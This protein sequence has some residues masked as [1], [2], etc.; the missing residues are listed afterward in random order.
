MSR[1]EDNGPVYF[2]GDFGTGNAIKRWVTEESIENESALYQRIF[3]G[4]SVIRFPSE[5]KIRNAYEALAAGGQ[6]LKPITETSV[7]GFIAAVKD[8]NGIEWN[9]QYDKG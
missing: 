8:R 3:S 9:L 4:D 7:G 6:I 1:M 5:A 2:N